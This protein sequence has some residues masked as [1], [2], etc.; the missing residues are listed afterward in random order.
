MNRQSMLLRFCQVFCLALVVMPVV[1]KAQTVQ[2]FTEPGEGSFSVPENVS[3]IEVD[4]WGGGGAGG[5]VG[6]GGGGGGAYNVG[7][8]NVVAGESFRYYVGNGAQSE[9]Q[10]PG[11]SSWFGSPARLSAGGGN[12]ARNSGTRQGATGSDTG[13]YTGGDGGGT[14]SWFTGGGGGSS[15]GSAAD[16]ASANGSDAGVAPFEGG[17]G[18]VGG[19]TFIF[20]FGGDGE[21]GAQPGGGG[22]GAG[23]G[24]FGGGTG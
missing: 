2:T 10:V 3:R 16:G 5:S 6:R 9:S 8:F 20:I 4:V 18:G 12:S 14:N 1:L 22:G 19:G 11:E 7:L 24:I 21:P 15:A 13:L 17:N 23:T